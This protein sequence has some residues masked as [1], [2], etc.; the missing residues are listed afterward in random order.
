[1]NATDLSICIE[2]VTDANIQLI[3]LSNINNSLSTHYIIYKIHNIE[4]GKHYIGQHCTDNP[5]DAYMGS[6]KLIQRSLLA[7]PL[8]SFVKEILFD[9]ET[10]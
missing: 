3:G 9:F 7:H 5:L 1:M 2:F 10:F 4:N 8:S 6:G